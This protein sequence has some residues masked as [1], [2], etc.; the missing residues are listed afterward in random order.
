PIH[1]DPTPRR[2][3]P[4]RAARRAR[5]RA[6]RGQAG[7]AAGRAI[8]DRVQSLDEWRSAGW[9][10]TYVSAEENEVD[11]RGLI[12]AALG[13][14]RRVVIP[15]VRDGT[16][17]LAHAV[18]DDPGA[19]VVG[20]WGLLCPPP[21]HDR[22]LDDLARIDL[23]LVPGLAFDRGGR[24]LGLGGGYYDRFLA[25]LDAP[26]AGLTYDCLLL[27]ELPVEPHDALVD[28]VVT[29]SA[30]IRTRARCAPDLR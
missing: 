30:A 17:R 20:P 4:R 21:G 7:P 16:R 24:R 9:V 25:Q 6:R 10:H 14:G 2:P 23:V 1:T 8:G 27:D 5:G 28:W 3:D 11:T 29:E 15:V 18:V 22:W 12:R 26:R 19:L 13:Q